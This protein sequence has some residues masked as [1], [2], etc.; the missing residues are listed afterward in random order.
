[1]TRARAAIFGIGLMLLDIDKARKRH[2]GERGNS[3]KAD[4]RFLQQGGTKTG[5]QHDHT[6]KNQTHNN[7]VLVF[8]I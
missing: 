6:K 8:I 2:D 7:V 1:M 5:D 3:N 4:R